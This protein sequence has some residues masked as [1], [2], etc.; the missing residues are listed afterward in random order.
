MPDLPENAEIR[1]LFNGLR[2]KRAE[3]DAALEP[4]RTA[5]DALLAKIQPLE[6]ELRGVDKQIRE[7]DG[8]ALYTLDLQISAL[9][10]LLPGTKSLPAESMK[11]D[12]PK[13]E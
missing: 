1:A 10:K 12:E 9:A 11:P 6:A 8:G 4:L 3:L 2:A 7:T 5:R 13:K